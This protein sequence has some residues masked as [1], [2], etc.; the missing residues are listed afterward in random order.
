MSK[1]TIGGWSRYPKESARERIIG[2]VEGEF[3]A[4]RGARLRRN[5]RRRRDNR[6]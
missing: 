6:Q 5:E 1:A 2:F 3:E 4:A